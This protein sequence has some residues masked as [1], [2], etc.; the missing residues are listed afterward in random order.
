MVE[1]CDPVIPT[2][3]RGVQKRFTCHPTV[4]VK[5]SPTC[6]LS[7]K[8][9]HFCLEKYLRGKRSSSTPPLSMVE[10][11]YI[12]VTRQRQYR[13]FEC[14]L[15]MYFCFHLLLLTETGFFHKENVYWER[16]SLMKQ[17]FGWERTVIWPPLL[18]KLVGGKYEL[19]RRGR[20]RY[21]YFSYMHIYFD[22]IYYFVFMS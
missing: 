10:S 19:S 18:T 5:S 13:I 22:T 3:R 17:N 1:G 8:P 6:R 15:S 11:S 9:R 14:H 12:T 4:L 20:H 16:M 7:P 21:M 2:S